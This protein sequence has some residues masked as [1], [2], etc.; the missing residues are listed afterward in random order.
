MQFINILVLILNLHKI[1]D[2]NRNK[3][4][5][6]SDKLTKLIIIWDIKKDFEIWK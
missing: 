3:K 1:K 4:C 6:F 2:L 5:I